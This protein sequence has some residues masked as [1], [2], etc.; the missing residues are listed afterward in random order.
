[1]GGQ[2]LIGHPMSSH[3]QLEGVAHRPRCR[4]RHHLR[5][6]HEPGVVIDALHD[7]RLAPIDDPDPP[8]MSICHSSIDRNRSQRLS[9]DRLRRLAFGVINA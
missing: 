3:R 8:T 2:G 6:D 5:R 7:L 4:P 1:M 9:S